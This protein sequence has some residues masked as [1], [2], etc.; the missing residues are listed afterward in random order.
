[1][2]AKEVQPLA[3]RTIRTKL[4]LD[5]EAEY[6]AQIKSTNA[7][8]RLLAAELKKADAEFRGQ[9][10]TVAALTAKYDILSKQ[11]DAQKGKVS[12]VASQLGEAEKA[13]R[14]YS[15]QI[16][17]YTQ[18][19]AA[20]EK[21]LKD[22]KK[23]GAESA[24]EE[25]R[26]AEAVADSSH[27]LEQAEVFKV[28]AAEATVKYKTELA[29]AEAG[30]ADMGHELEATGKHLEEA[31][32]STDGTADS[33]DEMGK[34]T[35][36][37]ADGLDNMAS[38]LA[39][40]GIIAGLKALGAA[41][42]E[43]VDASVE[44]ESAITGIYKTVD[45]T[46]QQLAALSDGVRRMSLE[47]PVAANEIAG[48]AENAGQ[49]GI[50][51][52][53]V[54][55]F[56][57]VMADLGVAT[58]LS[59]E[60][61]AQAFARFANITGMAQSDFD[62][63]GSSIVALGNNLAT[64][65]ADISNMAMG[66][67]A[68]GTQA[69]FSQADILGLAGALSSVGLEAQAGGSSFSKAINMMT[70]AVETGSA[71]LEDFAR[72]AGMSA[73]EFATAYKNDAAG[74]VISFTEGLGDM[75]RHGAS[76]VVLLQELGLTELRLRDSL[77]RAAGAGDLFRD[78]VELS[79]QA[80]AENIALTR[81]AE[82]RYG[83]T[84]SKIQMFENATTSL[85]V[86]IG[87]ALT[88]ALGGMAELG[89][90]AFGWMGDVARE[91]PGVVA[92]VTGVAAAVA[93]LAAGVG[94]LIVA[95]KAAEAMQLLNISLAANPVLLAA[96][97]VAGL[98]VAIAAIAAQSETAA[99][100][101]SEFTKAL[102]ESKEAY[103]E[104][105]GSVDGEQQNT[106]NMISALVE[107]AEV[108]D[109]SAAQKAAMLALVNDINA[110]MPELA[111]HYDEATGSINMT[112]EELAALAEAEAARESRGLVGSRMAELYKQ[113]QQA[114]DNLGEAQGRLQDA[115]AALAELR[116]RNAAGEAV[117]QYQM[118]EAIRLTSDAARE[119]ETLTQAQADLSVQIE[120][121]ERE[122]AA[123]DATL[124]A[125]TAQQKD[126]TAAI[127]VTITVTQDLAAEYQELDDNIQAV[128]DSYKTLNDVLVDVIDGQNVSASQILDLIRT[129]PE[130]AGAVSIVDGAMS[131]EEQSIRA[132]IEA[133]IDEQIVALEAQA[134]KERS[135]ISSTSA[136]IDAI[137]MEAQA[138]GMLQEASAAAAGL[139]A[140]EQASKQRL[141]IINAQTA[142]LQGLR[143]EV[144]KT[145]EKTK[146]S[147]KASAK[148]VKEDVA[149]PF[150]E[151]M[152]VLDHA[153][154]M[155][156]ISDAE[157]YK[158]LAKNRDEFLEVNSDEW[159]KETEKLYKYEK[160]LQKERLAEYEELNKNLAIQYKNGLI[161]YDSYLAELER[162][163]G[164]YHDESSAGWKDA[165]KQ[166]R[167]VQAQA[168]IDILD[169][170]ITMLE[171]FAK[172]WQD[173]LD[174]VMNDYDAMVAKLSGFG[175]LYT[176]TKDDDGN[177]S[178]SLENLDKQTDF[179]N[180]YGDAIQGLK[181][182]EIPEGLLSE[183][184]S[185]DMET[186][187]IYAD[188]INAMSDA[189]YDAY[190]TSWERKQEAARKIATAFYQNELDALNEEFISKIPEELSALKD[191]LEGIG[192]DASANA[193]EIGQD[194]ISG[195]IEGIKS[196]KQEVI[197]EWI[198]IAQSAM[199][200]YKAEMEQAS[201]SKAMA[202]IGGNDVQGL[203]VGAEREKAELEA[204]YEGLAAAAIEATQKA[205]PR[206]DE[207]AR[208]NSGADIS[209][210][211]I[212]QAVGAGALAASGNAT[213]PRPIYELVVRLQGNTEVARELIDPIDL[214][215]DRR[216]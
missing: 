103:D 144:G 106:R 50:A 146:S 59:G 94:A 170:Q 139:E 38:A 153:R 185:M 167:D 169:D 161:D 187:K 176:I 53:N 62:R 149:A 48:L 96:A 202:R 45:G 157:Y 43:C 209:A 82:L 147:A 105:R 194:N 114:A 16:E 214:E 182:R 1:M 17:E 10:N 116:T 162:L 34:K 175:D 126:A 29:K 111:L 113:E 174:Q 108:E 42:S 3:V 32:N 200:A 8:M 21:A 195:L 102:K 27:K 18:K 41:L 112:A 183:V 39:A 13:Q 19:V 52:E 87:D 30:L 25:A 2:P 191:E 181:D 99:Q 66:L 11:Y 109:K 55:D 31:K 76:A 37:A 51:T 74:A 211:I 152:A 129:Y 44:F 216:G 67:A 136:R 92:G 24:E 142:A 68:A 28:K 159:K 203:I 65:E 61:A 135:F 150:K 73:E 70:V 14:K 88:P 171:D 131:I 47:I 93:V 104:L 84:E 186:G 20:A 155:D 208:T 201:P 166:I 193:K 9:A 75:E 5:G 36:K 107:L 110:A 40:A 69:G 118:G 15:E 204:T 60:Q 134:Q 119:V 130:L 178:F 148:A 7:E 128:Q 124:A 132:L 165:T 22:Y 79:N 177:E 184:L 127:E 120:D 168:Q 33:L 207:P 91:H 198:D 78:S 83:T 117:S 56:S 95:K 64:T 101:T 156:E 71:D 4:V 23:S 122:Y 196:K 190:V 86:A 46:P 140:E 6:K 212:A 199:A 213:G 115:E 35:E 121:A 100:Q 192:M 63:L 154:A 141:A 172:D 210:G 125:A 12:A 188:R 77:T 80:W 206:Y 164:E 58:N 179:I 151:A 90:E 89:A 189:Q 143:G 49:L 98:V 197:D 81:E 133:Q 205:T 163:R 54:L 160:E 173:A 26:L 180:K 57:R 72:I 158:E 97:A 123:Y 138:I 145:E 137:Y 85:K 215:R